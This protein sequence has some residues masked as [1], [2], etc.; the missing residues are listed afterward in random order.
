MP[1]KPLVFGIFT[2]LCSFPFG[3]S[4]NFNFP[5]LNFPTQNSSN[6]IIISSSNKNLSSQHPFASIIS[7]LLN[8]M[9]GIHPTLTPPKLIPADNK[10][11]PAIA[12]LDNIIKGICRRHCVPLIDN[13]RMINLFLSTPIILRPAMPGVT[14]SFK[15]VDMLY[16]R[17]NA[18]PCTEKYLETD[19]Y[20]HLKGL[21]ELQEG[22]LHEIRICD[23]LNWFEKWRRHQSACVIQ[24][25]LYPLSHYYENLKF[26][27]K[28]GGSSRNQGLVFMNMVRPSLIIHLDEEGNKDLSKSESSAAETFCHNIIL[29]LTVRSKVVESSHLFTKSGSITSGYILQTCGPRVTRQPISLEASLGLDQLIKLAFRP[30]EWDVHIGISYDALGQDVL[31]HVIK[32]LIMNVPTQQARA[33]IVDPVER[34]GNAYAS[35]WQAITSKYHIQLYF[36]PKLVKKVEKH[37]EPA[38]HVQTPDTSVEVQHE[39]KVITEHKLVPQLR[40]MEKYTTFMQLTPYVKNTSI[41]P[42]NMATNTLN[43]LRFLSC[44]ERGNTQIRFE[45]LITAFDKWIWYLILVTMAL[46]TIPFVAIADTQ[47]SLLAAFKLLVEQGDPYPAT[48]ANTG[49][50]RCL[51][52]TFL[53]AGV[54]L[55]NA[56]KNK[57]LANII[58]PIKT[59]EYEYFGELMDD[60][61]TVFTRVGKL[62]QEMFTS[63]TEEFL[64]EPKTQFDH[65][66]IKKKMHWG[67]NITEVFRGTY[68][69]AVAE[70]FELVEA[71]KNITARVTSGFGNTSRSDII[72]RGFLKILETT[73]LQP[74]VEKAI[75]VAFSDIKT[76]MKGSGHNTEDFYKSDLEALFQLLMKCNKV[77]VMLPEHLCKSYAIRLKNEAGLKHVFIG[78]D[79]YSVV[80]SLLTFT[81]TALPNLE[82]RIKA[83]HES[84]LWKRWMKLVHRMV[85]P[86]MDKGPG[87]TPYATRMDGN[88]VI[89]FVM[90]LGGMILSI[91]F[92]EWELRYLS[93]RKV[94]QLGRYIWSICRYGTIPPVV[95]CWKL[96]VCRGKGSM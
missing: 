35:I 68:V 45:E 20:W 52:G 85:N 30:S 39:E 46:V 81:G 75:D 91:V 7:E 80:D 11:Y 59:L 58:A 38:V 21:P 22:S 65:L 8:G 14:K 4:F 55:S 19:Y 1:Q 57:N 74:F 23:L 73:K 36:H 31:S 86:S 83:A 62:K 5:N 84:G 17:D 43:S 82:T 70:T 13:P 41:V 51:M 71:M 93:C 9:Q 72:G 29:Q 28:W 40:N 61:F 42:Y 2:F 56:Y 48:V 24:I 32:R 12:N 63:L 53:L 47:T 94:L 90:W 50:M 26:Y 64:M 66:I 89:I 34:V 3:K 60:N 49:S 69:T 18:S 96:H 10:V 78:K 15:I 16:R 37:T 54:V 67:W 92:W 6:V 95:A 44:G 77:A 76:L 79:S 88:I 33:M 25:S 27:P 87:A